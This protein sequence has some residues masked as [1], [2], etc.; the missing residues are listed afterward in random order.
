[1]LVNNLAIPN[2][3]RNEAFTGLSITL[4]GSDLNAANII[5][6]YEMVRIKRL[7]KKGQ[8]HKIVASLDINLIE[9]SVGG[10]TT[11]VSSL[12]DLTTLEWGEPAGEPAVFEKQQDPFHLVSAFIAYLST[13][14]PGSPYLSDWTAKSKSYLRNK[15]GARDPRSITDGARICTVSSS[16]VLSQAEQAVIGRREQTGTYQVR[17]HFRRGHF[18]RRPGHG[19]DPAAPRVVWVRPT[20]VRA[21]RL[22]PGGIPG[23]TEAVLK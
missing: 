1:M 14:P 4:L 20:L 8:W 11:L 16:Y 12:G 19:H 10:V 21:D 18:R 15:R 17:P 2:Q 6:R 3:A 7:M 9:D 23:G 22:P 13:L 5:N